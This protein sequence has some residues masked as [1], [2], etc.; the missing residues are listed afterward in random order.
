MRASTVVVLVLVWSGV[1]LPGL[2]RDRRS[3]PAATV[4]G[5]N[6]AMARLAGCDARR[7][8][9]P[10]AG[11]RMEIYPRPSRRAALLER[12]RTVL[13]RLV[14]GVGVAAS[15]ALVFGGVT[16][17]LT[18]VAALGVVA[19]LGALRLRVVRAQQAQGV[20]QLHRARPADATVPV[21][22]HDAS[23]GPVAAPAP[24]P[25]MA[26]EPLFG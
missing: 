14:S 5:F 4:D 17:W 11:P 18:A 20:V 9:I 3:S 7:V 25:E 8:F 10:G 23:D 12:R 16:W 22:S 13:V 6:T 26:T 21:R 24:Q 1:L 2:L 15:F 19:Y